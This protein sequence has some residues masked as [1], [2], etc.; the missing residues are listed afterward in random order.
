MRR[1]TGAMMVLAA[2][3]SSAEAEGSV[4]GGR[5][6]WRERSHF[7]G[8]DEAPER[9]LYPTR[10]ARMVMRQ[11]WPGGGDGD[12]VMMAAEVKECQD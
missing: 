3:A 11:R 7:R 9:R 10:D 1:S 12:E 4:R 5:S 2:R 8:R 6:L